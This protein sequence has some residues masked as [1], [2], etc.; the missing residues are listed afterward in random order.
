MIAHSFRNECFLHDV[1]LP[2]HN[3]DTSLASHIEEAPALISPLDDDIV[4]GMGATGRT[5]T[6]RVVSVSRRMG[7]DEY[8]RMPE[9]LR[10]MELEF[11]FVREPP[12]PTFGHQSVVTAL[13]ALLK[14]HVDRRGLGVVCVSP[15]DVVLDRTGALIV[16]PD[17]IFVAADRR[18]IIHDRVWGAP[19]LVVEVLSPGTKR[20][21][22][23]KKLRWY[24]RYGVRE[25]WFVDPIGRSVEV[26]EYQAK[27]I[28]RTTFAG[29]KRIVSAVFPD[30]HAAAGA[31][32]DR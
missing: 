9:T 22:H 12:A 20:R 8:F 7:V 18:E 25:C 16:Q 6:N 21:D 29:T 26:V 2:R 28:R 30:W 11:G 19:D 24:G 1:Y 13:T 17:I 31:V 4:V 5:G 32:F 15:I 14:T 10:P 27:P 23:T 3:A